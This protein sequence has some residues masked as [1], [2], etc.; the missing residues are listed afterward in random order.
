MHD[1]AVYI[2]G[3]TDK[4]V[5]EPYYVEYEQVHPTALGPDAAGAVTDLARRTVA[6]IG[7]NWCAFHLECRVMPGGGAKLLEVAARPG[8]GFITSHLVPMST[9]IPFHENLVRVAT[10]GAPVMERTVGLYA[11]SRSVLSPVPGT[12][13]GFDG[14]AEV[15]GLYGLE[16]FAYEREVG[17]TV[18]LPPG[19]TLSAILATAIA[20]SAGYDDLRDT[21]RRA[22]ELSR[23]R[24]TPPLHLP[25][26]I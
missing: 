14:L 17:G 15:L 19:E 10:G 23:P 22:C 20:R 5:T 6:A 9:G 7:L 11:G 1:G 18:T 24:V 4:W 16:H 2:A 21:L 3:I 26:R 12:F 8:G 25:E 13:G